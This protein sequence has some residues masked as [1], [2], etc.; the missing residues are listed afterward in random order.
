MAPRPRTGAADEVFFY[1]HSFGFIL[2][3]DASRLLRMR[4]EAAVS[5]LILRSVAIAR[6]SKDGRTDGLAI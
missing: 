6:V 3:D 5:G 4:S 1:H 2:R